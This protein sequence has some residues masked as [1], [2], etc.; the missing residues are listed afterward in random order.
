[1]CLNAETV[2]RPKDRA[3]WHILGEI[4]VQQWTSIDDDDD[5]DTTHA[6]YVAYG[7]GVIYAEQNSA[8][9]FLPNKTFKGKKHG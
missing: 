5:D 8:F 2:Y 4:Y 9:N 7:R 1:M 3:Q 6:I